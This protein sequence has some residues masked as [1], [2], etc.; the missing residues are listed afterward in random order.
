MNA[1]SRPKPW[2]WIAM[3]GAFLLAQAPF[4]TAAALILQLPLRALVIPCLLFTASGIASAAVTHRLSSVGRSVRTLPAWAFCGI[5]WTCFGPWLISAVLLKVVAWRTAALL[6]L[7]LLLA[8]PV[9]MANRD[10]DR[11]LNEW[12]GNPKWWS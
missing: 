7:P 10:L 2:T 1:P 12:R 3:A 9:V 11:W 4:V 6:Y 8:M 5:V